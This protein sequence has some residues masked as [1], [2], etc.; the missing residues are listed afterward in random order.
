MHDAPGLL[1]VGNEHLHLPL[2]LFHFAGRPDLLAQYM[3]KYIFGNGDDLGAMGSFTALTMMG[4]GPRK[5]TA[6]GGKE[7]LPPSESTRF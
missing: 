5:S 1:Y 3:N 7:D 6:W 2:F 4:L